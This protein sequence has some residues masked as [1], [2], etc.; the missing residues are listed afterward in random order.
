M[1]AARG[2][3][4]VTILSVDPVRQEILVDHEDIK[5]F[6]ST[7][8]IPY[9]FIDPALL[10]FA[11]RFGVLTEPGDTSEVVVHNLRT[12]IIEPQG[13]LVKACSGNMWSPAELG[14]D[15][16]ATPAAAR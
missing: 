11:K 13:H 14:A 10:A 16:K 12:A 4:L 7:M 2:I 1:R 8:T 5:G 6:M 15:L 3:V 9:R